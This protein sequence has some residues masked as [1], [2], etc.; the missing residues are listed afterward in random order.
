MTEMALSKDNY[1]VNAF[2]PDRSDQPLR[3]SVLPRR[4][5]R[6]GSIAD[7]H[8]ANKADEY[9]AIRS[10]AVTDEIAWSLIPSTGLSEL[11]GNPF[12]GWMRRGLQ[13]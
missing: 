10:V 6:Y 9:L 4:P 2:P 8:G 13:P 1:M 7:A 5:R 11:P 3:I 12:R